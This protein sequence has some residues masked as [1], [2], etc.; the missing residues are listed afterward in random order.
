MRKLPS[1]WSI[2]WSD[3][4]CCGM[5]TTAPLVLFIGLAIKLTG[6]VPGRRG[7]PDRPVDPD[8]A[9]LVLACAVGLILLLSAIVA[10]RVARIRRLFDGGREVEASVRKLTVERGRS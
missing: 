4:A 6:T 10:R 2:I 9:T 8:V 3:N 5:V 7:G 1:P